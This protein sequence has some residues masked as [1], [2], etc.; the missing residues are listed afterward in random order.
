MKRLLYS[1]GSYLIT[2]N[3][4]LLGSLIEETDFNR[5]ALWYESQKQTE[6][7]IR[8]TFEQCYKGSGWPLYDNYAGAVG[9]KLA[10]AVYSVWADA[11]EQSGLT[12][13]DLTVEELSIMTMRQRAV[14]QEARAYLPAYFQQIWGGIKKDP[15]QPSRAS[16]EARL[17][18]WINMR[19]AA[20]NEAL[21]VI[22]RDAKL[23]WIYSDTEHCR[24]CAKYNGRVY[25]A[26]T[27]ARYGIRPQHPSLACHGFHCQCVLSP[28]DKPVN[29]GK[30]PAMTG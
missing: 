24:D 29:K 3:D 2:S 21:S 18:I 26:S 5:G 1:R 6:Q 25:R 20:L 12:R 9:S 7:A 11:A 13:D 4:R 17:A 22:S 16:F 15:P 19:A 27:W 14:D 23:E 10:I 28:T 30:P 8:Q